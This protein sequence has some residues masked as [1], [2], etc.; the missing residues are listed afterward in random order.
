[1]PR[2]QMERL[3]RQLSQCE[4]LLRKFIPDF[5]FNKLDQILTREGL[6][7]DVP[8]PSMAPPN[9]SYHPPSPI[10]P[11]SVMHVPDNRSFPL[12]EVG[13]GGSSPTLPT[14]AQGGRYPYSHQANYYPSMDGSPVVAHPPPAYG[15]SPNYGSPQTPQAPPRPSS[16]QSV[17]SLRGQ[18]PK[19]R[20]MSNLTNVLRSFA[21]S[22]MITNDPA[23]S[24][25]APISMRAYFT[26]LLTPSVHSEPQQRRQGRPR[27][28]PGFRTR[29]WSQQCAF[30]K[31]QK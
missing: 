18:D 21:V 2:G 28:W 17:S 19:G 1:M 3:E 20:D 26:H 10:Y 14:S 11:M 31:K 12:R 16:A 5:E 7:L 13:P 6:S 30:A 29:N 25:G 22:S 24:M 8:P 9:S 15:P 4:T 27:R 23:L